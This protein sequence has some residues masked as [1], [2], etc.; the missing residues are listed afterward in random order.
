MNFLEYYQKYRNEYKEL[1]AKFKL[2]FEVGKAMDPDLWEIVHLY[3]V[4]IC[5]KKGKGKTISEFNLKA[6]QDSI[7]R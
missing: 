5:R 1:F 3:R 4:L 7:T 2:V 6:R